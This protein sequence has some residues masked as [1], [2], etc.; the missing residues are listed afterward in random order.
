LLGLGVD[1]NVQGTWNKEANDYMTPLAA[2]VTDGQFDAAKVLVEHGAKVGPKMVNGKPGPDEM[3]N[4]LYNRRAKIVKLFWEHRVRSIS[5]LTYA[6][7]QGEPVGAMQKLLDDG[8]PADP[9]QDKF[10]S[11]LVLAAELGRMDAVTLLVQR[12][13]KINGHAGPD[14]SPLDQA[15]MEGQDEVVDYLL[16]HGAKVD[17]DALWNA[18]WNC[19]PYE[20]QRSQDHFEKIVK[21]LINAGALKGLTPEQKGRILDAAIDTRNPGG[22]AAVLKMLLDAGLSP[23]LPLTDEAGKKFGSVVGYY[24]DLYAKDKDHNGLGSEIKPLLDILEAAEKGG[25]PKVGR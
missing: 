20:D 1:P 10:I 22:N 7:S 9:P 6:I 4:A 17:Y 13:A 8:I 12:G 21:L 15:A 19:H 23:D 11:P 16:N 14:E 25:E 2:A 3:D 18:S 5:E 24:R